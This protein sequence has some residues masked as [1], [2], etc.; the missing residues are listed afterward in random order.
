MINL[1]SA[2]L[3]GV[4]QPNSENNVNTNIVYFKKIICFIINNHKSII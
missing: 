1:G 4:L 3:V 2:N